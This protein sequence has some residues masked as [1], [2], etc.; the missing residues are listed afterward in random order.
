MYNKL[1]RYPLKK[2]VEV[3]I[4]SSNHIQADYILDCK[5]LAC[6]MPIVKTKKVMKELKAGQVMEVQAT[7]KGSLADFQS[8]AQSTGHQFIGTFQNG[9]VM[10]HYLRKGQPAEAKAEP[11]LTSTISHEELQT[12]LAERG[13]L[14]LLDVREPAEFA[15]KHIPG[16]KSIPLGELENRLSELKLNEE[17]TVICHAGA[18]SQMACQLLAKNGATNVKSVLLGISEWTGETEGSESI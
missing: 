11:I 16:S 2:Q 6:P 12:K 13:N 7:D 10:H 15:L 4:M 18:R 1:K 8:W 3:Y 9:N 5:G 14:L 17:I